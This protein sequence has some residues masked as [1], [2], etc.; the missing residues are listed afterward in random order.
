MILDL[1][2][3]G[4][5]HTDTLQTPPPFPLLFLFTQHRP[6]VPRANASGLTPASHKL[7][8]MA[9]VCRSKPVLRRLEI[10]CMAVSYMEGGEGKGGRK[11]GEGM[12]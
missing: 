6:H 7:T 12:R 9:R 11:E 3:Q 10:S 5:T 8:R 2:G 4:D 1:D